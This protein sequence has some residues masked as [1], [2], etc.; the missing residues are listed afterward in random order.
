[1]TNQKFR[2][3]LQKQVATIPRVYTSS[4][5]IPV[6]TSQTREP[7]SFDAWAELHNDIQ[8]LLLRRDRSERRRKE[9]LRENTELRKDLDIWIRVARSRAEFIEELMNKFVLNSRRPSWPR[10]F[11]DIKYLIKKAFRKIG[12]RIIGGP[13]GGRI[14]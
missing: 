14:F 2:E 6:A 10:V 12:A 7:M 3:Q 11:A 4:P 5:Q 8:S 9:L 13:T 1:M